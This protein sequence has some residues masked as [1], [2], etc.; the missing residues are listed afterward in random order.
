MFAFLIGMI[1]GGVELF[2]LRQLVKALERQRSGMMALI[3]FI[4][5]LILVLTFTVVVLFFRNDILWCGI[6]LVAILVSGS[7]IQFINSHRKQK[8]A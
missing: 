2:L 6:G 3:L 7:F 8:G 4:K 1:G 5:L